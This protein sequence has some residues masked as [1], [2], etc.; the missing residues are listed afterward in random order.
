MS[1]SV[2]WGVSDLLQ[3]FEKKEDV[4]CKMN[5]ELSTAGANAEDS[6]GAGV[7]VGDGLWPSCLISG[8]LQPRQHT[9]AIKKALTAARRDMSGLPVRMRPV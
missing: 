5:F 7:G 1:D 6:D 2:K 4:F 9:P 3:G 8:R